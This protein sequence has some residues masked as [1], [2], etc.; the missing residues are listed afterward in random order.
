MESKL[1]KLERKA[2]K[3][4]SRKL[5]AL[6]AQN[7][8]LSLS[9]RPTRHILISNGGLICGIERNHL[10]AWFG[11]YGPIESLLMVPGKSFSLI[12]F[13]TVEESIKAFDGVH[14]KSLNFPE[15]KPAGE[16]TLYLAY[17]LDKSPVLNPGT[18]DIR[19]VLPCQKELHPP[20]LI[21][22]TDFVSKEQ[23]KNLIEYFRIE[24]NSLNGNFI[25]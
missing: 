12:S 17:L 23:E 24:E 4:Q 16:I 7:K 3:K 21:L 25:K 19:P 15:Q 20:G 5:F 10:L 6:K 13:K 9:E 1:S 18:F 8:E 11:I 2:L 14:G 22:A